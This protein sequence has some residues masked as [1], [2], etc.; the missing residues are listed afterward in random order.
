MSIESESYV[1]GKS[2]IEEIILYSN[3]GTPTYLKSFMV[4]FNLYEDI[5]SPCLTGNIVINDNVDLI[6]KVPISGNEQ[7][8]VKFRT[9]TFDDNPNNII[10]KTFQIYSIED[11]LL[12]NDRGSMYSLGLISVEGHS[13]QYAT[14]SKYFEGNTDDVVTDIFNDYIFRGTPL[15]I[16]DTP[17][18]SHISY[19]SNYWS[20]FKNLSFISKKTQGATLKGSDFLFFESNKSFY[21][22]SVESLIN[23]QAETLFDEYAYETSPGLVPRRQENSFYGNALPSTGTMITEIVMPDVLDTLKGAEMGYY[24]NSVRGYDL[25]TKKLTDSTFDYQNR[26]DEF[27]H[28]GPGNPIPAGTTGNPYTNTRFVSYNTGLFSSYGLTDEKD[29]PDNHPA[30]YVTDR[31]HFRKSYLD[32]LNHQ[33]FEITIPGRT[34]IQV[35]A[36]IS[37]LFPTTSSKSSDGDIDEILDRFLSGAYLITA[38]RHTITATGHTIKAEV[39]RNGLG[40]SYT[41]KV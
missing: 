31:I 3:S 30:Q 12:N 40:K 1:A 32:S 8:Y 21:F 17:H 18:I 37:I 19:I 36:L 16:K 9:L 41:V 14:I 22:T 5:F 28:T 26:W 13:D 34:D 6:N 38:M 23:D 39:V 27:A 20:P 25:T 35:G 29:L 10:E 15:A 4:E 24:A 7:L 11:R 2:V 33:K